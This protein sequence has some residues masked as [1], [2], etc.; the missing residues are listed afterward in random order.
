MDRFLGIN[1]KKSSPSAKST[2]RSRR[3]RSRG[4]TNYVTK[5]SLHGGKFSPPTNPPDVSYQPWWP[6]TLVWSAASSKSSD[7]NDLGNRLRKQTDPS[8]LGFNQKASDASD[9]PFRVQFRLQSVQAWNLTGR[10]ISLSVEDFTDNNAQGRDQLCGLVDTGSPTHTPAVGYR[11]PAS[12][13]HHVLRNDDVSG[14]LNLFE[15]L[16]GSNDALVIYASVLYR[17]DGP[18]KFPTV[19]TPIIDKINEIRDS[20]DD[21]LTELN[22]SIQLLTTT[23]DDLVSRQPSTLSKVVDGVTRVAAFV[24]PLAAREH[25]SLHISNPI[26][27]I[28]R[29]R[30]RETQSRETRVIDD[31]SSITSAEVLG[32]EEPFA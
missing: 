10:I 5:T 27:D 14:K 4:N 3:N 8:G 29:E 25:S 18:I 7:V 23:I 13:S 30:I 11:L 15:V 2:Q 28:L 16:G 22:R 20:V 6:I 24:V 32:L 31:Q 12:L 1:N 19:S 9:K 17:F 21:E 26:N